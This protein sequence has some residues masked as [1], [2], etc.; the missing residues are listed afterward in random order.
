MLAVN[1]LVSVQLIALFRRVSMSW[2]YSSFSLQKKKTTTTT[3]THIPVQKK[4]CRKCFT[5][6]K[7]AF[8]LLSRLITLHI[9]RVLRRLSTHP[10][11]NCISLKL[12]PV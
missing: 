3:T 1:D 8:P 6:V 12:L 2:R 11:S 10:S 7:P 9:K 5:G 4:K